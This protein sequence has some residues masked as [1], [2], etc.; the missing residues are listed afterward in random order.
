MNSSLGNLLRLDGLES[1]DGWS[2]SFAAAWAERNPFLVVVGCMVAAALAAWFYLRYQPE[3]RPQ[4]RVA[5]AALRAAILSLLVIMLADPVLRLSFSHAP[6]PLLWLLFDGTESMAI[7]DDLEPAEQAAL[8]KA[9]G[10][11]SASGAGEAASHAAPRSRQ[12]FV[13]AWVRRQDD[14]VL[15]ALA[16]KF[17]LKASL[18]HSADAVRAIDLGDDGAGGIDRDRVATQLATTGQVTALGKAFDDLSLRHASGSLQG[19]VVVSDF[20]Q[21]AG[22]PAAEAAKKLGVPVYAVGVGPGAAIDIAVDLQAPPL[23]KKSERA[24]VVVT[25]RQMGLDGAS[26]DVTVTARPLDGSAEARRRSILIGQKTIAC[27]GPTVAVEFPVT[28]E[29]VGRHEFVVEVAPLEGETILDNNRS[30]REV[31]IRDDFLRLMDVEYE[32]TWEWRFIKEVFHRDPLVGMRGFRTFLRSA[33]TQVRKNNELFL[34][35]PAPARGEFFANDVIFL[36]DMPASAVNPRFCEM[37]REFVETFGGGLVVIAGN[38]FGPGQLVGTPLADMLPVV[39]DGGERPVEEKPFELQLAADAGLV[40]F[41]QLGGDDAENRKAWANLGPLPWYQPVARPH[42]QA[43]VL[44]VHPTDTC[45]DGKTR[46]PIIAIRRYGRGEVV[47]VGT[48]ETWRLRRKYGERY[49]RQFWGQMIHRL[50]LS[51]ALGS[52]KRFVVRTDSLRYQSDD[53]VVVTVEAYDANFEPL[54]DEALPGRTLAASLFRPDQSADGGEPEA[55]TLAQLRPGVFEARLPVNEGGGYRLRVTDPVTR[56]ESE[57]AFTVTS[58]S[59]ERRSA[60]R[61]VALQQ[62][63]AAETSGRAYDLASAGG[64]VADINPAARL[65]RSVRVFPLSMT[66]LCL[67]TGLLLMLGEWLLRKRANLP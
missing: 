30:S 19:V 28:P 16:K 55:V 10:A 9:V 39:L 51:H 54:R 48:N 45:V 58:L 53:T 27:S 33:D 7:E 13:A 35:T 25:L 65:E 18:M 60:V 6:R 32:P 67:G 40:D 42:P 62:A 29:E 21:N 24:A 46:Q 1:I 47:Y 12:D 59:A 36:G 2:L 8:A 57:V 15:S 63:L 49:Y 44:A 26:A 11:D 38:R 41:M 22:P 66:W 64:L 52:Q 61:N 34:P 5:L 56:D 50:G 4:R 37:T 31:N 3:M 17:R 23:L 20:D 43:T 14:N